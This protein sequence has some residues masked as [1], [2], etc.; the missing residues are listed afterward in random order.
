MAQR[1]TEKCIL[2]RGS[3]APRVAVYVSGSTSVILR[4]PNCS[5]TKSAPLQDVLLFLQG[6]PSCLITVPCSVDKP[7]FSC[8]G[9]KLAA[10]SGWHIPE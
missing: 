6:A 1:P 3:S 4:S 8:T 7:V 5:L 2:P 9:R 10:S